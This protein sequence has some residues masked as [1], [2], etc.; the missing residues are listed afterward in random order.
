MTDETPP[1]NEL[2]ER[3]SAR[4]SP[5]A[6]EVQEEL[7]A[8]TD[9]LDVDAPVAEVEARI[10]EAIELMAA[11]PEDDRLLLSQNAQLKGRAYE[12]RGAGPLP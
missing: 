12:R 6:R 3:L 4:L 10:E 8:L 5:E 2:I 7:D 11:L 1:T 9:T